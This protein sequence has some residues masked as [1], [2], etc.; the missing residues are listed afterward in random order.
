MNSGK[1]FLTATLLATIFY[2]CQPEHSNAYQNQRAKTNTHHTPKEDLDRQHQYDNTHT[3]PHTSSMI[4]PEQSHIQDADS[5]N[6]SEVV[7]G[8]IQSMCDGNAGVLFLPKQHAAPDCHEQMA[9]IPYADNNGDVY[10]VYAKV[11]WNSSNPEW[12]SIHHPKNDN[13]KTVIWGVGTK[14]L[15]DENGHTE[16]HA[17]FVGC[18]KNDCTPT[19]TTCSPQL[20]SMIDVFGVVNLEGVWCVT[21]SLSEVPTCEEV[22]T[23][24]DGRFLTFGQWKRRGIIVNNTLSW[25]MGNERYEGIIAPSRKAM[26]GV[27]F[28]EMT[29]NP[30]GTWSAWR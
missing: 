2:G 1:I 8:I 16:P 9:L 17:T 11:T 5:R 19:D 23:M 14:D 6:N 30:I 18:I 13:T 22:A 26:T 28:D 3:N 7:D 20:C 15:F 21:S 10:E 27:I 24:Q 25:R 29:D 12:A 4:L